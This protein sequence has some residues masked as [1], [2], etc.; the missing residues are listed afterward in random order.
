MND[1]SIDFG[2]VAD[3]GFA[4]AS[5]NAVDGVSDS[6]PDPTLCFQT[7]LLSAILTV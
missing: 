5:E 2:G 3:R 4:G 1:V 6:C 7:P